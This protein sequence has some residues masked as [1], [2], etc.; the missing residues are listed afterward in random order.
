MKP[1]GT[2]RHF[3][4]IYIVESMKRFVLLLLLPLIRGLLSLRGSVLAWLSGVWFDIIVLALILILGLTVWA[5]CSYRILPDGVQISTGVLRKENR[6]FP[7]EKLSSLSYEKPFY[8]IPLRAVRVYLDTDAGYSSALD[9][10]MTIPKEAAEQLF[11]TAI[12]W[13][14]AT[15]AVKRVYQ[16][17]FHSIAILS[18]LTSSTLTGAI[19]FWTFFSQSGKIFG[20]DFQ[21]FIYT[22]L[23]DMVNLLAFGLPPAAAIL[24]YVILGCWLLAFLMGLIRY[25]GFTAL[26]KGNTVQINTGVLVWRRYLLQVDRIHLVEIRQSLITKL[27]GLY[28]VFVRC[29]GYGK[30]RNEAAVLMPAANRQEARR[31][32]GLVLPEITQGEST[33]RPKPRTLS[34]FLYIP[35]LI[36][37]GIGAAFGLLIH[38]LHSFRDTL[39]FVGIMAELPA[40]WYLLVKI[41]SY[42]HTGLGFDGK[43]CTCRCTFGFRIHTYAVPQQKISKLTYRQSI[44]QRYLGFCDLL[45]YPYAERSRRIVVPNLSLK[46]VNELLGTEVMEK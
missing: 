28:S 5:C 33:V 14:S 7:Y 10:S 36:I 43:V 27:L 40:V 34:R 42:F 30:R 13:L 44:F 6:M 37:L 8:L 18:F 41:T 9:A 19:Y 38:F 22:G 31:T 16:P 4:P 2:K 24:A 46:E 12:R 15:Q 21:D 1:L 35:I 26:R 32:L 29:T 17:K 39:L 11:N 20:S 23:T 3:H 25:R 45:I